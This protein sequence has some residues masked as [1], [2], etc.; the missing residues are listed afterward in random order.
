MIICAVKRH[1]VIVFLRLLSRAT[2]ESVVIL[3]AK[4]SNG[5]AQRQLSV[6]RFLVQYGLTLKIHG[7]APPES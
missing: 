5:A 7:A 6:N 4:H 1:L 3:E 2:G